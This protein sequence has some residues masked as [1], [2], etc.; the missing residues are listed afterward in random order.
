MLSKIVRRGL[1]TANALRVPR[2][3]YRS[4]SSAAPGQ[5]STAP[6]SNDAD[7]HFGFQTIKEQDKERMVGEVFRRVA[8]KWVTAMRPDIGQQ[9]HREAFSLSR[10]F[11][12]FV[13]DAAMT[14]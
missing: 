3:R 9:R 11:G 12:L 2:F 10:P 5:A 1:V 14:L 13:K 4:L 8:D 7:T 6:S